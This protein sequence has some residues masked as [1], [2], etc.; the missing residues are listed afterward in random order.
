PPIATLLPYT[1]LF[2]S[3]FQVSTYQMAV[4]LLFNDALTLDYEHIQEATGLSSDALD[5][6]LT[7]FQKAKVLIAQPKDSKPGA[8][9][10]F[11]LNRS[12]EHTSE[13][14]SRENL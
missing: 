4:L 9:V 13:F 5:P 12:E 11:T 10:K 8:G 3:T 1:T 2:R 6:C 7:V 14:Q